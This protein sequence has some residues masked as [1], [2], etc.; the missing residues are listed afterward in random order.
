MFKF[1]HLEVW[2]SA[3]ALSDCV[4]VATRGFPSDERFGLTSQLRRSA[5]SIAA[6]IAEGTGRGNDGDLL[7]FLDIAYGSLMETV[8]HIT[9][10]HRQK[11]LDDP[12]QRQLYEDCERL[13]KMINAFK[14]SLR[15]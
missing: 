1:E 8:S 5:V 12:T 7:R 9:I 4:Y 6:N 13:A 15:R 10:A 11:F 2:K 14:N 3:I